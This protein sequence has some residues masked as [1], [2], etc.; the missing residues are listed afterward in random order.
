MQVSRDGARVAILL[1]TTTGPRLLVA[2]ILRDTKQVPV[3]LGPLVVDAALEPGDATGVTWV[4]ELTVAT[5]VG[6][7]AQST[8]DE[9]TI[10]GQHVALGGTL[11]GS[12]SIVGGNGPQGLQVLGDDQVIYG[13]QG[14]SWQ[15]TKVKVSFI[16]TQQ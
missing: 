4:D 13:Y 8:V 6:I 1:S 7:G 5:L 10:G 15:S 14:S 3:G 2:A 9:F 16:A 11:I 12:T